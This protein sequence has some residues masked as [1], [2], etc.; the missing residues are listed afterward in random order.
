MLDT[1]DQC[2]RLDPDAKVNFVIGRVNRVS[3]QSFDAVQKNGRGRTF[4]VGETMILRT[5]IIIL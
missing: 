5:F 1:H 2:V 4:G 3:P